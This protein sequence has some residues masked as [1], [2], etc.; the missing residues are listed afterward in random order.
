MLPGPA[1]GERREEPLAATTARSTLGG[2]CRPAAPPTRT[3]WRMVLAMTRPLI[4]PPVAVLSLLATSVALLV[5]AF[6]L[7]LR[8]GSGAI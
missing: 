8:L 4:V 6:V 5:A 7:G 3:K 1:V 2:R